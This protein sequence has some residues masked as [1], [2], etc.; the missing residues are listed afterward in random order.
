MGKFQSLLSLRFK[1]K[2]EKDANHKMALLAEKTSSGSLSS[3]SGIFGTAELND[4]EKQTIREILNHYQ[5]KGQANTEEDEKA[6]ISLTS[7]VKAITN[8]AVI[9]H[10]ERIKKA[11]EILTNYEE[12]AFSAW[13]VATYG[14]RQTP[15]NFLQYF[16]FLKSLPTTLHDKLDQMPRQAIYTLASRTGDLKKKEEV[17]KNYAG[18]TKQELLDIIR[19]IFP[20]NAKDKRLPNLADQTLG[21][22]KKLEEIFHHPFFKP[23]LEQKETMLNLLESLKKFLK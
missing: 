23:S 15:Y 18:Q 21:S 19:K 2:N 5:K 8:Q 11:Q 1:T 9:L 13:L 7:E 20:L 16:E 10:G 4:L 17:I 22:L 3:F 6:L 12:G 14:N